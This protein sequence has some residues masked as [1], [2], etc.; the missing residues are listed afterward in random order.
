MQCFITVDKNYRNCNRTNV[1]F[2]VVYL[3]YRKYEQTLRTMMS[4]QVVYVI[5]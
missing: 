1:E 3:T 4:G 5:G 2:T